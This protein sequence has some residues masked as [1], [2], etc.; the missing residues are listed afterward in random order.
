MGKADNDCLV[1]SRDEVCRLVGLS[2]STLWRE[3]R[4]GRFPKSI[5]LS[6]NRRGYLTTEVKDWL[7][8]KSRDR[9]A[10]Q[11][12]SRLAPET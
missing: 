12:T 4:C 5:A 3:E 11:L 7:E 9:K 2:R 1:I 6:A 10:S 8:N